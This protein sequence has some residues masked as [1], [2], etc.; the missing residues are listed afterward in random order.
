MLCSIQD[1]SSQIRAQT[2]VPRIEAWRVNQWTASEVPRILFSK[3]PTIC[4]TLD[5]LFELS[6]S[7]SRV[8]RWWSPVRILWAEAHDLCAPSRHTIH[9][10][11][12]HLGDGCC[13]QALV[14]SSPS[15]AFKPQFYLLVKSWFLLPSPSLEVSSFHPQGGVASGYLNYLKDHWVLLRIRETVF[16]C[17]MS[18]T[19]CLFVFFINSEI[20]ELVA[21]NW[22]SVGFERQSSPSHLVL[23]PALGMVCVA[24]SNGVFSAKPRPALVNTNWSLRMTLQRVVA[25]FLWGAFLSLPTVLVPFWPWSLCILFHE[26]LRKPA[27]P[28]F[29]CGMCVGAGENG[30]KSCELVSLQSTVAR[31]RSSLCPQLLYPNCQWHE[32]QHLMGLWDAQKSLD[33]ELPCWLVLLFLWT[34]CSQL[35]LQVVLEAS[36]QWWGFCPLFPACFGLFSFFSDETNYINVRKCFIFPPLCPCSEKIWGFLCRW[37]ETNSFML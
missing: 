20:R 18:I 37:K 35:I 23:C 34:R 30:A 13:F 33:E 2:Q 11:K 28:A 8:E 15:K 7:N 19:K 32:D 21:V 1:L 12:M 26:V 9:S 29:A 17:I 27:K 31:T 3:N 25:A 24:A 22:L 4:V 14:N 6:L 36:Y 10:I 16:T 5:K